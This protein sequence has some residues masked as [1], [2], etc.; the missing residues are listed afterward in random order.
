MPS[1]VEAD[2]LYSISTSAASRTENHMERALRDS[3]AIVAAAE[4]F[5]FIQRDVARV[6]AGGQPK[7]PAF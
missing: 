4:S 2:D 6:L 3:H 1:C 5:R 7:S